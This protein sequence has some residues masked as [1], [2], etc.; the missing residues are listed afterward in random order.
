[1]ISY[2]GHKRKRMGLVQF[3]H[4]KAAERIASD[5]MLKALPVQFDGPG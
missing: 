5:V 4:L 2:T 3:G 1:M